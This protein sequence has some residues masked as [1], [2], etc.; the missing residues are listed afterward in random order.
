[1]ARKAGPGRRAEPLARW[2]FGDELRLGNSP[3]FRDRDQYS[4][5]AA[6][7]LR[8]AGEKT[9][10]RIAARKSRLATQIRERR[11]RVAHGPRG[12]RRE[13]RI[14]GRGCDASARRPDCRGAA[15]RD[16][17]PAIA[18]AVRIGREIDGFFLLLCGCHVGFGQM[19]GA[20]AGRGGRGGR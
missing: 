17:A 14:T 7:V 15:H 6:I 20:S 16:H 12:H 4:H 3:G 9:V 5:V 11:Q 8:R 13:R 18:C 1:M 10:A 2:R 19:Q